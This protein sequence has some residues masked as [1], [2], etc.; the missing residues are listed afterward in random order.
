MLFYIG[1]EFNEFSTT[2]QLRSSD[3]EKKREILFLLLLTLMA[4]KSETTPS[5]PHPHPHVSR[6]FY[7]ILLPPSPS[8]HLD[9]FMS[10]RHTTA[11]QFN[12]AVLWIRIHLIRIPA[13]GPG[14][15]FFN[16]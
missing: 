14:L 5:L 9:I 1:N 10:S 2:H 3:L 16:E 11:Y 12:A 4:G 13:S 7:P 15:V 6:P 8:S